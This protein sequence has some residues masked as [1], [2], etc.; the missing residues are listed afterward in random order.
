M[1]GCL[2]DGITEGGM[3]EDSCM[4]V[5][6]PQPQK[7]VLDRGLEQEL[8]SPAP[9]PMFPTLS[10]A[11]QQYQMT[12]SSQDMQCCFLFHDFVYAVFHTK[13]PPNPA[14]LWHHLFHEVQAVNYS[15]ICF[16]CCLLDSELLES[17]KPYFTFLLPNKSRF[18]VGT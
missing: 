16:S 3:L 4:E 11:L 18:L 7:M 6:V 2:K 5:S 15:L 8:C 1:P 9:S 10:V 14:L 13:T 12:P 17:K